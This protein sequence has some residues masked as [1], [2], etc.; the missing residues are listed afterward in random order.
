MKSH[1]NDKS[2]GSIRIVLGLVMV[3]CTVSGIETGPYVIE[4]FLLSVIGLIIMFRGII[5]YNSKK[6]FSGEK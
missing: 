4:C 2:T 1:K 5:A 6:T 3:L